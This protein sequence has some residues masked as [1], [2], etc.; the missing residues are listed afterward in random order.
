MYE[1]GI[2]II[3]SVVIATIFSSALAKV[4]NELFASEMIVVDFKLVLRIIITAIVAIAIPAFLSL[5]KINKYS[6]DYLM[7][8]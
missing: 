2:E 5:A 7:R 3:K 8:N 4:S 1:N 6:P